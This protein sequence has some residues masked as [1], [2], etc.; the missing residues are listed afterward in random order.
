MVTHSQAGCNPW[1]TPRSARHVGARR[2]A[3]QLQGVR[4]REASVRDEPESGGPTATSRSPASGSTSSRATATARGRRRWPRWTAWPSPSWC[5]AWPAAASARCST[6][7]LAALAAVRRDA[8]RASELHGLGLGRDQIRLNLNITSAR[9]P[10]PTTELQCADRRASASTTCSSG[11][12]D[13]TKRTR[14]HTRSVSRSG[15]PL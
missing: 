7:D 11:G 13:A 10:A 9:R 2:L 8:L 6:R 4:G 1:V 14:A 5:P 15:R 12:L 3:D